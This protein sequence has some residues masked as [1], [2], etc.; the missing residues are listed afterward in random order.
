MPRPHSRHGERLGRHYFPDQRANRGFGRLRRHH[1]RPRLGRCGEPSGTAGN[2]DFVAGAGGTLN[3][4]GAQTT[5]TGDNETLNLT[6][7]GN[8]ASLYGTG[9]AGD[10]VN[11]SGGTLFL[12]G[13][14]ASV[15]G[16]ADTLVIG[17]AANTVTANGTQAFVFQPAFG[18]DTIGGFGATDQATFSA[19]DFANWSALLSHTAQVGSNTVITL[20]A[21]DT[22]TLTGVAMSSLQQS[23]FNFQ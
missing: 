10:A 8:I 22:V 21:A 17:G 16:N 2:W 11:G 5:V 7:T 14:K 1:L 19:G 20:D 9:A 3:L 13:V 12:N 15:T 23:Q 6:G 18:Q 4:N